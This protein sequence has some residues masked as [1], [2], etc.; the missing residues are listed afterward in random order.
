MNNHIRF[1]VA[2]T[3]LLHISGLTCRFV[4]IRVGGA[5]TCT[6]TLSRTLVR[7]YGM[8]E[9]QRGWF[10]NRKQTRRTT[11]GVLYVMNSTLTTHGCMSAHI[12]QL[13]HTHKSKNHDTHHQHRRVGA[14]GVFPATRW[15]YCVIACA[16]VRYH[17]SN[18]SKKKT[19]TPPNNIKTRRETH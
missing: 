16:C 5:V 4:C 8:L 1:S 14:V 18:S 9:I 11:F 12:Y 13:T 17:G 19:S 3:A 7:V 10:C 6:N 15:P 2:L